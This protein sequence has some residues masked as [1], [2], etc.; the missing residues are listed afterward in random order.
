MYILGEV[1]SEDDDK[2]DMMMMMMTMMARLSQVPEEVQCSRGRGG[3]TPL[4]P[5]FP[6]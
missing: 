6:P 4:R 2:E 1:T 3:T 5:G